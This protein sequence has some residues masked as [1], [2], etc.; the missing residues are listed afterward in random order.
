[1]KLA[2]LACAVV[3]LADR[4]AAACSCAPPPPPCEV[5]SRAGAVFVGKVTS[6]ATAPG[7]AISA[8]FAVEEQFKGPFMART[9]VVQGG[10]MCGATFEAGKKYFVYASDNGGHWYAGLCGRTRVLDGAKDDLAY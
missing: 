6:V 2:A 7:A 5:Y 9:F 8:T 1:M 10:G 3:L 4:P